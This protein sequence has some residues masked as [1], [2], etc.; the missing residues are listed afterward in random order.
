M[1]ELYN[2][3]INREYMLPQEVLL[4]LR[5]KFAYDVT[6]CYLLMDDVNAFD[7]RMEY[8]ESFEHG[9]Y[10]DF[11]IYVDKV[12]GEYYQQSRFEE[13]YSEMWVHDKW[14][15]VIQEKVMVNKYHLDSADCYIL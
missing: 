12:S 1:R 13:L 10:F 8:V 7:E 4:V 15:K 6:V 2:R 11:N 9:S 14:D 5:T 3:F